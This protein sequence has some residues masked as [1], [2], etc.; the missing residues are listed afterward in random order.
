MTC[1]TWIQEQVGWT[2][3]AALTGRTGTETGRQAAEGPQRAVLGTI[4]PP[5]HPGC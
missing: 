4:L 1:R 2:G 3:A 5:V